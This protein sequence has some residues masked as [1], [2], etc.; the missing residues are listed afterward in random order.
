MGMFSGDFF[1][2]SLRMTT[3]VKIITPEPSCDVT[4]FQDAE[5]NVMYL[6]HGLAANAGEWPR[7][8]KIEYY[9]K[10]YNLFVVM[11]ETQRFFYTNTA[12][13]ACYFDYLVDDLP[14][15]VTRWFNVPNNREHTFIAGESMG[16]YGALKAALSR[17]ESY[18]GAAAF[19]AVADVRMFRQMVE[20]KEFPDMAPSEMDAIFGKGCDVGSENDLFELSEAVAGK[21]DKPKLALFC[22]SDDMLLPMNKHFSEH[23]SE[24][25]YDHIFQ[26][27][28][29]DHEWPYWDKAVQRGFQALL[30]YD[31]D[32]T[33]L[34]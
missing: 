5:V 24:L 33:P 2:P 11:P 29:G 20:T 3:Q 25:G 30:G 27:A 31:L 32:T 14:S 18:A 10:K 13:G 22:G 12:F 9:A 23:L 34:F 28:P 6:L 21:P 8:S 7:F 19:S 16:G 17:P 1:S 15:L 26:E 4:P